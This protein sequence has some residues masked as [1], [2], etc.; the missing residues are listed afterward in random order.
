MLDDTKLNQLR[1]QLEQVS[2]AYAE[3]IRNGDSSSGIAQLGRL[4]LSVTN[5]YNEERDR[6]AAEAAE[7]GDDENRTDEEL[8]ADAVV[9]LCAM[10]DPLLDRILSGVA[11]NR[12]ANIDRV[13]NP[14]LRVVK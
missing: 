4:Q 6:I 2:T 9:G 7:R 10:P 11:E 5:A 1:K 12:P 3:A 13:K 8:I 14:R